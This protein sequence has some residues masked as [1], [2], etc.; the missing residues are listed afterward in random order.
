MP[1]GRP[2]RDIP[3][4]TEAAGCHD[5]LNGMVNEATLAAGCVRP[6]VSDGKGP[7]AG[8]GS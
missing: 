1:T 8:A 2:D 4:R 5:M 6:P 7:F 3:A